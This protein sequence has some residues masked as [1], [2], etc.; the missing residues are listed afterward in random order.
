MVSPHLGGN[1]LVGHDALHPAFVVLAS[2]KL[3]RPDLVGDEA[4][5]SHGRRSGH[6]TR[7]SNGRARRACDRKSEDAPKNDLQSVVF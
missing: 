5:R 7:A 6:C 2:T 4:T 1:V 3:H